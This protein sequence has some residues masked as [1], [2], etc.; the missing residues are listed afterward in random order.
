[1]SWTPW[2]EAEK[3]AKRAVDKV[4]KPA[5]KSLE[6]EMRKIGGDCRNGIRVMG[7]RK[8]KMG[9]RKSAMR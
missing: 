1:M 9:S 5:A 3:Q 4:L 8:W 2:K 7:R 6:S